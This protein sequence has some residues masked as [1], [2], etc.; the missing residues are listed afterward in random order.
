MLSR[1]VTMQVSSYSLL[2][3]VQY[4]I[5]ILIPFKFQAGSQYILLFSSKYT[6]NIQQNRS[7]LLNEIELFFK[8]KK[9]KTFKSILKRIPT[10]IN[11]ILGILYNFK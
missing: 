4:N 7:K 8:K 10:T 5:V 2:S 6:N 3:F 1:V 11:N 9:K